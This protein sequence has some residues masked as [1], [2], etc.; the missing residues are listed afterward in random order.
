M[1]D[2]YTNKKIIESEKGKRY[3][4]AN[5]LKVFCGADFVKKHFFNK[6]DDVLKQKFNAARFEKMRR[7]VYFA[8]S[9][10]I[11]NNPA[12]G[13]DFSHHGG[14]YRGGRGGFRRD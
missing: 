7:E 5:C 1:K 2:A 3:Q 4:C 13:G 12:V 8:D 10:K 6:H 11:I 9:T 14:G